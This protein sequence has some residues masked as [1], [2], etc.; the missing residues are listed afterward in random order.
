MTNP[1]STISQ[2]REQLT[3]I[4]GSGF[5][6]RESKP[7]RQ[8]VNR[9]LNQVARGGKSEQQL[10]DYLIKRETD[11]EVIDLA[12]E[13]V[14]Q[15]GFIDDLALAQSMV[16]VRS[17][18]QRHSRARIR[19]DLLTKKI[20]ASIVETALAELDPALEM[21]AALELAQSRV[22]KLSDQPT[23]VVMRRVVGFLQRRGYSGSVA[24]Q[25]TK[26]AVST[27]VKS[28]SNDQTDL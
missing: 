23:E 12:I 22:R 25:A 8:A 13:K 5:V 20:P 26:Q 27:A 14:A 7:L 17:E 18:I 19:R 21:P 10:R 11:A 24:F 16:R 1:E 3:T 28:S 4:D 15:L 2:L 9:L 6:T